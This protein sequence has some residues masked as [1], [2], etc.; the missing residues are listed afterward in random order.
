[1]KPASRHN[2][3][4]RNLAIYRKYLYRPLDNTKGSVRLLK[5]HAAP[6]CDWPIRCSLF[7]TT[8]PEAPPY[9]ALSYV[10][11]ESAGS[12]LVTVDTDHVSVTPNLK[13]AL[14]RLRPRPGEQDLVMWV[15]A[16]CINQEDIPERNIQT[17]N[18]R[19]VYQHAESVAVF[20][21]LETNRSAAAMMFARELNTCASAEEVRRLVEDPK[22][23]EVIEG[24][25]SL[26]RRQ[27]WWRIW[28]IQEVS[29]AK[30]ATVYCGNHEISWTELDRVCDLLKE[31]SDN[32]Q[33]LFYKQPSYIRTLTFGGP[34][35]LQL[36]RFSRNISAPPLLELLLTHKSKKSTDP[37]DKVYALIGVSE[38]FNTFGMIDY[39]HSVRDVYTHTARHIITSSQRLD[40]ICVKQNDV[41]QYGLP[42]WAPDWTR[43]P[44][45]SGATVVGLHHHQP[46]FTASGDAPANFRFLSHGYALKASGFIIDTIE[47]VGMAFIQRSRRPPSE[48][49]PVLEAFHDWWN[50]F[51][52]SHSN[53]TAAQAVFG[54]TI[55]CGTW[56]HNDQQIYV[57]KLEAIFSLSDD[58]LSDSDMLRLNPPSRPST[59]TQLESSTP[60]LA[61]DDDS[62]QGEE[63]KVQL[64]AILSAGL[65][66]NRRRFFVSQDNIVG[67]APA[68]AE[69]GDVICV[70]L[71]C[72]YP[73][74][75]RRKGGDYLLVGEAY[76][77]G[78]M[79]GEAV[80]GQNVGVYK[81]DE[82]MIH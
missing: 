28:V 36:S 72:R 45:N 17:R 69:Q 31:V 2:S 37:K 82:F 71:G 34:R 62:V 7:H 52:S 30:K 6:D 47:T 81:P 64:S 23:K 3:I 50:I 56:D 4:E 65:T 27:Y 13:H 40:V 21:G 44:S 70:L 73:V 1:M 43:P 12:Q 54:R 41:D 68:C 58:L 55:S 11:G 76:V 59:L 25:V 77:D 57:T 32:L 67:L 35:G 10:W 42:S 22:Q 46:P 15:D 78:Y 53:S 8:F 26:F 38:S 14:Q 33:S 16:I 75:L 48:V 49:V 29:S 39:S 24:L 60:S 79:Y 74:V 63:E 5:L 61:D 80:K 19:A 51:V 9:I 20:L 18:M 66:M